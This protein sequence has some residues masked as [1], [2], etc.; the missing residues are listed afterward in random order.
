MC[1]YNIDVT[2]LFLMFASEAMIVVEENDNDS[3]TISSSWWMWYLLSFS[4]LQILKEKWFEK[5]L[6]ILHLGE[7]SEW[8]G[9]KD[10]KLLLNLLAMLT[11]WPLMSDLCQ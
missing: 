11:K 3:K 7:I 1:V 2:T 6:I 4:L 10:G 9:E 8:R 5:L